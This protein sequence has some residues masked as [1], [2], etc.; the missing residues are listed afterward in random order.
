MSSRIVYLDNAAA[1]RPYPE[2]I[3]AMQP[4]FLEHFGNPMSFH[5][6]GTAPRA[7]MEEAR[8][9]VA[10]L[11]HSKSEEIFFTA[12]GTESN[13]FAVKGVALALQKKG[14]HIITSAI[15]HYGVHHSCKMLERMGFETTYLP[16][17]EFGRVDPEAVRAALREDTILVSIMLANHE[18][19][20]IQPIQEI[21]EITR[22][23][24]VTLHTDA[25]MAVGHI[26]VD[27]EALGVDLLTLSGQHFYGPKGSAALYIRKGVRIQPLIHGGVQEQGRRAGTENVP[28]IVGLGKA[29]SIAAEKVVGE[30][31]RLA[32]LRD[33]LEQGL[34]KQLDAVKVNGDPEK[35]LPHLLNI[36]I[37]YVEGEGMIMMMVAKGIMAASGSACSS[38][39]LKAS[40][41]LTAMGVDH[42]MAQGSILFSLGRET[43]EEE[44]D[45]VLAEMPPI[46]E[47]LRM[48]SPINQQKM[49]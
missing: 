12:S 1:T 24:K 21:A 3:E 13:N 29:A 6:F 20:T 36:C 23:K 22:E 38:K 17:D 35:R 11:I 44:I 30:A 2:V 25:R 40:H 16:V 48:M 10:G 47:R 42:A 39:A 4:Y 26:P 27:V 31:T 41:V 45:Y 46:V 14:K 28:A 34:T 9:A 19:G 37:N 8:S 15:E 7:A 33:K 5:K 49:G 18:V 43:T 32:A